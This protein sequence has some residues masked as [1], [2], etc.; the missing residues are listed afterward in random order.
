MRIG[1]V[2]LRLLVVNGNITTCHPFLDYHMPLR[3]D[4]RSTPRLRSRYADF[5]VQGDIGIDEWNRGS[6][7]SSLGAPYTD[8]SQFPDYGSDLSAIKNK[9]GRLLREGGKTPP[10]PR[11]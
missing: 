7:D 10:S 9:G 2:T 5:V 3:E 4:V 8:W 1:N 6:F 11:R